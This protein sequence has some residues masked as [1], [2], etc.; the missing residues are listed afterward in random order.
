MSLIGDDHRLSQILQNLVSNAFKY[1][2][3]GK[4]MI[5]VGLEG[6]DHDQASLRITVEDTGAGIPPHK[7]AHIFD[8]YE[9][10]DARCDAR[11]GSGLGLSICKH[12]V[13]C[14]GAWSLSRAC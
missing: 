3:A 9:Q 13:K 5:N 7:L 8:V 10:M 12:L 4:V 2:H 11:T 6:V 14:R 1:T